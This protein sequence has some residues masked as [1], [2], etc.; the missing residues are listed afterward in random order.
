MHLRLKVV[1]LCVKFFAKVQDLG[2]TLFDLGFDLLK[3]CAEVAEFGADSF[4]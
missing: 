3:T 2:L 1:D 4:G